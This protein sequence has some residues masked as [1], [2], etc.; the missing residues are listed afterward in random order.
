MVGSVRRRYVVEYYT[1]GRWHRIGKTWRR[2]AARRAACRIERNVVCCGT[3]IEPV[4][5]SAWDRLYA[6]WSKR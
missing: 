5:P 6:Y 4:I 3:R 2:R 1:A